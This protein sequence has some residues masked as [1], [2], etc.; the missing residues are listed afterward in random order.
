MIWRYY[1]QTGKMYSNILH[2]KYQGIKNDLS[3]LITSIQ[4]A[5]LDGQYEQE[6]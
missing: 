6:E 5:F 4:A 1:T 2:A 3:A